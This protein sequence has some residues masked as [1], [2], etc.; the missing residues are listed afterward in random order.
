MSDTL[1]ILLT[2]DFRRSAYSKIKW[3][4]YVSGK[5]K[6]LDESIAFH[7]FV[8][9]ALLGMQTMYEHWASCATRRC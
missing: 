6:T 1:G 4:Q 9:Q 8:L 2:K 5:V 7:V 3:A